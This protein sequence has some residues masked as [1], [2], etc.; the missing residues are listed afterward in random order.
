[1]VLMDQ[2]DLKVEK[3]VQDQEALKETKDQQD[4]QER[5]E[6]LEI[7]EQMVLPV[8]KENKVFYEGIF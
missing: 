6:Y 8:I 1:M 2:V 3:V 7:Q 5:E 4:P